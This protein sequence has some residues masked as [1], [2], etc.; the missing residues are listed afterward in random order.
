[1]D[2]RLLA[3]PHGFS[4]RATSF[5]A[6][7]CQ[8]IHRT[9]FSCS[10]PRGVIGSHQKPPILHRNHPTI[11]SNDQ[12]YSSPYAALPYR[13]REQHR[14]VGRTRHQHIHRGS[15][16]KRPKLGAQ[17]FHETNRLYASE[18]LRLRGLGIFIPPPVRHAADMRRCAKP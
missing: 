5:I 8:G 7:W 9:P 15:L 18:H 11:P 13:L 17:T 3:A 16:I 14:I 2:Q 12:T 4:Q 10:Q 6:S 1:M